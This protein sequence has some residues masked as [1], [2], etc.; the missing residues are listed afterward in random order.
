M[1]V[2]PFQQ[3]DL[4]WIQKKALSNDENN[5]LANYEFKPFKNHQE[6][7]GW[8]HFTSSQGKVIY[9]HSKCWILQVICEHLILLWSIKR[10]MH[11]LTANAINLVDLDT[12]QNVQDIFKQLVLNPS[13]LYFAAKQSKFCFFVALLDDSSSYNVHK[14]NSIDSSR[15][16]SGSWFTRVSSNVKALFSFPMYSRHTEMLLMACKEW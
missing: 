16:L 10:M 5:I 9:W 4:W 14:L 3:F 12:P 7:L 11:P 1:S 6:N 2:D 8:S 15:Y 13:P